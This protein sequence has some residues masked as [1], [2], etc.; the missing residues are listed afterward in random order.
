MEKSK[1]LKKN[2]SKIKSNKNLGKKEQN[3]CDECLSNEYILFE[4][5]TCGHCYIEHCQ[6]CHYTS[7][8]YTSECDECESGFYIDSSKNCKKCNANFEISNGYCSGCKDDPQN[9]ESG[10]CWCNSHYTLKDTSTCIECPCACC[11][12]KWKSVSITNV[13]PMTLV[14]SVGRSNA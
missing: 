9:Y 14:L 8:L 6:K 11:S 7:D 3:K 4:D 2:N 12:N 5:G 10:P 1:I 13:Q